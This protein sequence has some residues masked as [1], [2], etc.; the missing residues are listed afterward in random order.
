MVN[1]A[2]PMAAV[3]QY[4]DAFNNADPTGM[5]AACANPMQTLDGMA[6]RIW[7]EP[8]AS[9]EWWRDVLAEGAHVG[10]SGYQMTLDE[11]THVDITGEVEYVVLPMTMTF[12]LRGNQITQTGA[13]WTSALRRVGTNWR[14]GAWA[15]AEGTR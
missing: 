10:A 9:E 7:H 15:W 5:A 8:T 6:P 11:P 13:I 3:R 4:A 1:A 14:L 2:D 12:D